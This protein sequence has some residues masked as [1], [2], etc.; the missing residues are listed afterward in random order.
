M[1]FRYL[2]ALVVVLSLFTFGCTTSSQA[3][4]EM[5][6]QGNPE[7]LRI[8]EL[9]RKIEAMRIAVQIAENSSLDCQG[10]P[11][12]VDFDR[13]IADIGKAYRFVLETIMQGE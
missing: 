12:F 3:D 8:A 7:A 11:P 2:F 4:S 13:C 6:N 9:D 5:P 10:S 1:S